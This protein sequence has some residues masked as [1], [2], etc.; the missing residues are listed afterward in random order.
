M[1]HV[2]D[3]RK[4]EDKN[5]QER[6]FSTDAAYKSLIGEVSTL[7]EKHKRDAEQRTT[8]ALFVVAYLEDLVS[9]VHIFDCFKSC[10]AYQGDG[11]DF[12]MDCMKTSEKSRVKFGESLRGFIAEKRA[13]LPVN[14]EL[15]DWIRDGLTGDN[16]YDFKD[17]LLWLLGESYIFPPLIDYDYYDNSEMLAKHNKVMRWLSATDACYHEAFRWRN[18]LRP[19]IE[20]LEDAHAL[21]MFDEVVLQK[22]N[23]YLFVRKEPEHYVYEN[24]QG[25]IFNVSNLTLSHFPLEQLKGKCFLCSMVYYNGGWNVNGSVHPKGKSSFIRYRNQGL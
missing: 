3:L 20:F 4:W 21:Q 24:L 23:Y 13:T 16:F 12:V 1:K 9:E 10:F 14:Q 7:L 11:V 18:A 15:K 22:F 5:P 2:I 8:Y 25:D 6:I 17:I 19:M